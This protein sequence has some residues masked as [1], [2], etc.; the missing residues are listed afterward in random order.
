MWVDTTEE[1]EELCYI[2]CSTLF[3]SLKKAADSKEGESVSSL[4]HKMN[5]NT[6]SQDPTHVNQFPYKHDENVTLHKTEGEIMGGGCPAATAMEERL[7]K[8]YLEILK[9]KTT[10]NP[11]LLPQDDK[12]NQV[13]SMC[14]S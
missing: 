13:R 5:T 14:L 3:C 2:L 6:V 9:K 10:V 11:S 8:M 7:D 4:L 12:T 1:L